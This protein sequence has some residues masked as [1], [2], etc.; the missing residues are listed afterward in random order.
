MACTSPLMFTT[1]S[2]PPPD[3][4][5]DVVTPL[6]DGGSDAVTAEAGGGGDAAG[7]AGAVETGASDGR[8]R[9]ARRSPR[10]PAAG[11]G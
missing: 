4:G 7:E 5:T 3:A 6:A 9:F 2:R 1:M 11:G 8:D 10:S